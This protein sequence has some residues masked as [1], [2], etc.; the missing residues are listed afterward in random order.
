M[1]LQI[2]LLT[3]VAMLVMR[4]FRA[5]QQ[6]GSPATGLAAGPS[7]FGG[8]PAHA[9]S[10]AMAP[11]AGSATS[12]PA[13]EIGITQ[14]DL[15][16]FERR[17]GEVQT[18]YGRED[19][20]A[21]RQVTT[22]EAMSY[23]A[24]ELGENAT[25][26]VRNVVSDVHLLQG[27]VAEAWREGESDYATLAMRYASIDATLDRATDKVVDGDPAK[28]TEATEVW[29]FSRKRGEDWKLSAIQA[30]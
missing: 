29:T 15:D 20:V 14:T 30:A 24:E 21:L 18:A 27:N 8:M 9:S 28:P 6:Q 25:R 13:D 3:G 12:R 1:L 22:P 10:I 23:L 19:Y 11:G 7:I 2:A 26:G 16:M 17:L 5:R 4:F